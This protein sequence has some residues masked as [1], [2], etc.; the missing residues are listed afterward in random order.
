MSLY[1]MAPSDLSPLERRVRRIPDIVWATFWE[2]VLILI[3]GATAVA[4]GF[5]WLFTSLG[6]TAYELAEKPELPSA[7]LYNVIVGHFVAIGCGFAGVAIL[8]AWNA[9]TVNAHSIPTVA[10]MGA[11]VIAVAL[12]VAINLLLRSGQPAAL[13]T[14]LLVSLGAMQTAYAA[15]WLAVG[16]TIVAIFGEPIRRIRLQALRLK[17]E[18][19]RDA[20]HPPSSPKYGQAA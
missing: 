11:A 7:R 5:P 16:V 18:P 6:P 9:P 10:R 12:T 2:A 17:Q 3:A 14:T 19:R 13:A 8:G 20:L 4:S 1:T 15:L